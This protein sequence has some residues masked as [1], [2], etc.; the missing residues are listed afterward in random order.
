MRKEEIEQEIGRRNFRKTIMLGENEEDMCDLLKIIV[1]V[2]CNNLFKI[3]RLSLYLTHYIQNSIY[4]YFHPMHK[5][6][7]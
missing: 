6:K 7:Y 4:I 2:K 1:N 5:I 3:I